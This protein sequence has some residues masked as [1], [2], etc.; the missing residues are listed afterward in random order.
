MLNHM[1]EGSALDEVY[2][3][4][5]DASR[6]AIVWRLAAEGELKV[7]DV[8]RPF[9]VSLNAISKH[10]KMLERAG[11]VKRRV[12]GRDHWLSLQS[13]PLAAAYSWI[14]LYQR[15]WERRIESLTQYLETRGS[16][17]Q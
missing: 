6:R 15:F 14:G 9:D 1:V 4:L 17:G 12:A 10:I 16:D 8:A 11:L 13:E 3:A 5:A 2:H 7:T